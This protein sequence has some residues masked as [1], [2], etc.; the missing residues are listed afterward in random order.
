MP[1]RI[2]FCGTPAFAVPSLRH[3]NAQPDFQIVGVVT[4]PDRPRGRGQEIP[5]TLRCPKCGRHIRLC[6]CPRPRLRHSGFC[7]CGQQILTCESPI[8]RLTLARKC[9]K[10]GEYRLAAWCPH[11]EAWEQEQTP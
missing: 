1:L 11:I 7:S 10:C 5:A 9:P 2:V 8:D 3:L 6:E 4:Q